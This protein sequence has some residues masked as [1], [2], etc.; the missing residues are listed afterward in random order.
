[1]KN[2]IAQFPGGSIAEARTW[3][4][5]TIMIPKQCPVCDGHIETYRREI[6][7]EMARWIHCFAMHVCMK[8]G[9]PFQ[10][11]ESHF[12]HAGDFA[13]EKLQS[14]DYAK[15]RWWSLIVE[16]EDNPGYWALTKDGYEFGLGKASVRS[17]AFVLMNECL[18]LVGP[19]VNLFDCLKGY[20]PSDEVG[21]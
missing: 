16:H 18:K 10:D 3:A 14:G 20:D 13:T 5:K 4:Q 1:M 11:V 8:H 15:L 21:G 12:W 9:Y 7:K 2:K 19:P 17:T 6:S